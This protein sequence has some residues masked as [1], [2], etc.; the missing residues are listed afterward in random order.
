MPIVIDVLFFK[1]HADE[2]QNEEESIEELEKK[3]MKKWYILFRCLVH[4]K[5]GTITH[6]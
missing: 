5:Q 2:F 3:L 4:A 6:Y 1:K